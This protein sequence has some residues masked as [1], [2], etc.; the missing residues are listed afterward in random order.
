MSET[1]GELLQFD[2]TLVGEWLFSTPNDKALICSAKSSP[3][4]R[5]SSVSAY[6]NRLGYCVQLILPRIIVSSLFCW[7]MMMSRTLMGLTFL[8]RGTV[9]KATTE[10]AVTR[11]LT[12]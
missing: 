3:R 9:I 10:Y 12:T 5:V 7:L 8:G 2:V 4:G 6:C 1:S 11:K